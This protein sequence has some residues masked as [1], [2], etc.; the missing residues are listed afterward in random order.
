M[1]KKNLQV[2]GILFQKYYWIIEKI[3]RN[4]IAYSEI[5]L[6][7]Q[8]NSKKDYCLFY[9]IIEFYG[10]GKNFPLIFVKIQY[11]NTKYYTFVS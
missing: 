5:L 9:I 1:N 10:H 11:G 6:N 3:L 2:H 8:N 4:I 7:Y